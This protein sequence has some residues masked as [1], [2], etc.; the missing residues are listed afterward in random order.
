MLF[1]L[2]WPRPGSGSP[3][4]PADATMFAARYLCE[5]AE[6]QREAGA[7]KDRPQEDI[8]PDVKKGGE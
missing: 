4:D 2:L 1:V 5:I 7:A 8:G 3:S 6:G